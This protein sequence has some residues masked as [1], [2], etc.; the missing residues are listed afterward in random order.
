LFSSSLDEVTANSPTNFGTQALDTA[1]PAEAVTVTN[2]TSAPVNLALTTAGADPDDFLITSSSTCPATLAAGASCAVGVRFWPSASGART[3]TLQN[4]DAFS[5]A[6]YEISTLSGTGGSTTQGAPTTGTVTVTDSSAYTTQLTSAPVHGDVT[7]TQSTGSAGLT[8]SATGLVS[9]TG[10][11]A[12][13][14]YTAT[15]TTDDSAGETGSFS[16]T[17]T[18]IAVTIPLES[19]TGSVTVAK[20]ST[21]TAQLTATGNGAVTFTKTG[22]LSFGGARVTV[23]SS[24]QV[25]T[26]GTLIAGLPYQVS[27]TTSDAYGDTGTFSFRLTVVGKKLVLG[28]P[29]SASTTIAKSSTYSHQLSVS[30]ATGPVFYAKLN[31]SDGGS[32]YLKVSKT[33]LIKTS[34]ALA[35]GTYTLHG[36]ASDAYNETGYFTF[37]LT[38]KK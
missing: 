17:L 22:S 35:A 36:I 12:A 29:A 5:G 20:S 7:Y 19:A 2:P 21:Y 11:L 32:K 26:T 9:T 8:V 18:V 4:T 16:F 38:I 25:K 23:S 37:T 15:G 24:G 28:A 30:G 3:A 34:G 6:Q 1:G 10:I 31:G 13:N 14:T 27:G 33:G